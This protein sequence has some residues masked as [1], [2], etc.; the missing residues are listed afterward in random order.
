MLIVFARG[1]GSAFRR[2]LLRV[3]AAAHLSDGAGNGLGKLGHAL[4]PLGRRRV[5]GGLGLGRQK[6]LMLLCA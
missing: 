2:G 5:A 6:V 4:G 3:R 1:C